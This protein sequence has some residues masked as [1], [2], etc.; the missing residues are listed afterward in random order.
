[1]ATLGDE[2][3]SRCITMSLLITL[4]LE[5]NVAPLLP[6]GNMDKVEDDNDEEENNIGGEGQKRVFNSIDFED[7]AWRVYHERLLF[8]DPL[9]RYRITQ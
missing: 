6:I 2:N 1:M 4:P 7:Y 3:D 9:D 8:K 5:S